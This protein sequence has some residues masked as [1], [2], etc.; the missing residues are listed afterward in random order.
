MSASRRPEPGRR[1]CEW[2]KSG[3]LMPSRM[4]KTGCVV[5]DDVV[6]ALGR[7]ELHREASHV[8][9]GVGRALLAGDGGEPL[10]GAGRGAGLEDRRLGVGRHVAGDDELAERAAALRVDDAL[11]DALAVELGELLDEV[12]VV[13]R[14]DA[15]AAGRQR[16]RVAGDGGSGLGRGVVVRHCSPGVGERSRVRSVQDC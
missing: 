6:V 16:V 3:N 8:A 10:E 7:V 15:V 14:G 4:K 9:P 13:Q 5:A 2:M 11:R 12:A 1:F